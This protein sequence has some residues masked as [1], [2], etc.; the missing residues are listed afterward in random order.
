MLSAQNAE[1]CNH[2]LATERKKLFIL[3]R[4]RLRYLHLHRKPPA[5]FMV[6]GEYIADSSRVDCAIRIHFICPGFVKPFEFWVHGTKVVGEQSGNVLQILVQRKISLLLWDHLRLMGVGQEYIMGYIA[7]LMPRINRQLIDNRYKEGHILSRTFAIF[8]GIN[9]SVVVKNRVLRLD[10]PRGI[11]SF[12]PSRQLSNKITALY[13]RDY[14]DAMHAFFRN[15]YDDCIRRVITAS[16]NFVEAK[17]WRVKK[18]RSF[19]LSILFY[20]ILFPKDKKGGSFRRKLADNLDK[21]KIAG[22]VINENLQF[23]Y[24]IRNKIV[25]GGFRIDTR[26]IMFCDKAVSTLY[27]LIYRHSGN[28]KISEYVRTLNKQFIR[29]K[30]FLGQ[31]HDLDEIASMMTSMQRANL[32]V[33]DSPEAF[34]TWIFESLLFTDRD[35]FNV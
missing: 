30:A 21:T 27:Y 28:S 22:K 13:V 31:F 10:W 17:G 26:S 29:Q 18:N 25:H 11:A 3:L 16:E 8:E 33:I 19:I 15:E 6:G 5:Q 9:V 23:I 24:T 14:I 4:H 7:T 20:E 35:K 12:P 32:G 1:L 34:E 2:A